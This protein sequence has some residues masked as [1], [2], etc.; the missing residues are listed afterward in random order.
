MIAPAKGTRL[1]S[2][3]EKV[4]TFLS[5]PVLHREEVEVECTERIMFTL[6]KTQVASD[7]L[8]IVKRIYYEGSV[9]I[10]YNQLVRDSKVLVLQAIHR[11]IQ[12]MQQK[13]SVTR[14][15]SEKGIRNHSP[16]T[17]KEC[18]PGGGWVT[19]DFVSI[20]QGRTMLIVDWSML[21]VIIGN[22]TCTMRSITRINTSIFKEPSL[23]GQSRHVITFNKAPPC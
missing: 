3:S 12:D 1:S 18:Q 17:L 9:L 16:C 5:T 13:R 23:L 14:A 19:Y 11:G 2:T 22:S 8:T 20:K 7:P 10:N 15:G 4:V 6:N 21:P